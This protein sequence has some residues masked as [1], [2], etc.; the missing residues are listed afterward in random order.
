MVLAFLQGEIDSPRFGDCYQAGLQKLGYSRA[1]LI[2]NANLSSDEQN[3]IRMDLL[4]AVR[5]Y[6]SN[7]FL[8]QGFPDGVQWRRKALSPDDLARSKY[9]NHPT[10]IAI[11]G[12][13][14]VAGDGAK[15]I[16]R[17]VAP[18]NANENIQAVADAMKGGKRY[19]P[20]IGV[21]GD[22]GELILAEGHPRATAHL[23]G[24]LN[25]NIEILVG[26]SPSM[27]NW[28]FY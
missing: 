14:R 13:S 18:E 21:E 15:N 8:F 4:K 24:G 10:W 17:K 23:L 6:R 3:L 9:A 7:Q 1:D 19:P 25:E 11:S 2:D 20:L 12:G 5:G 26:T 16:V 22:N 28:A 27:K